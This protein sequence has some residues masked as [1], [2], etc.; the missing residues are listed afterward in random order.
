MAVA[1]S[2]AVDLPGPFTL[3]ELGQAYHKNRV[4]DFEKKKKLLEKKFQNRIFDR[5][6]N[7]GQASET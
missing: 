7:Y 4:F 1:E 5:A 6:E 2:R 3:P